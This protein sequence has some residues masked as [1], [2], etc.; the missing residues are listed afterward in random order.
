MDEQKSLLML[1]DSFLEGKMKCQKF[2]DRFE[3]QW[4]FEIGGEDMNEQVLD[5][6]NQLFDVVVWY[7][8]F[9]KDRQDYPGYL[10]QDQV[11]EKVRTLRE[12]LRP[13]EN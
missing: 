9:P 12:Q 1:V 7:S 8:P 13:L 10:D 5:L 4:N 6:F 3:H 2:C 11:K